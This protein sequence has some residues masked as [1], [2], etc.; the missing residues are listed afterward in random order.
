MTETIT[1]TLTNDNDEYRFLSNPQSIFALD[2]DDVLVASGRTPFEDILIDGGDGTDALTHQGRLKLG[3]GVTFND[4]EVLAADTVKVTDGATVDLSDFERN[5]SWAIYGSA[6]DETI[7]GTQDA[8]FIRAGAGNDTVFANAGDIVHMG[9]GDDTLQFVQDGTAVVDVNDK[10]NGTIRYANGDVIK[11]R[12]VENFEEIAPPV[13]TAEYVLDFNDGAAIS[14]GDTILQDQFVV[15][16]ST[17]LSNREGEI[18]PIDYDRGEVDS[19]QE[20]FNAFLPKTMG[21]ERTDGSDFDFKSVS[22]GKGLRDG[23]NPDASNLAQ[24]VEIIGYRDGEVAFSQT[25]TLEFGQTVTELNFT[26][27]D[28]L[29]FV[30]SGG[31]E[32]GTGVYSFDDLVFV[33]D[34]LPPVDTPDGP[35]EQVVDFD[36]DVTLV[37][38]TEVLDGQFIAEVSR[39]ESNIAGS[40]RSLDY[41]AG[42]VDDDLEAFNSWG[43]TVG[44][45]SA[46]GDTFDF[47]SVS[48][49][50]GS[51]ADKTN[52]NPDGL[53]NTVE[54]TGFDDGVALFTQTVDLTD[55]H[56]VQELNWTGIDQIEFR[57]TGGG[58]DGA[59]I[60]NGGVFSMDDLVFIA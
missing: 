37:T 25:V 29:E 18:R 47:K 49:A 41:D 4:M 21:F 34:A 45:R 30:A 35:T 19:D 14:N 27:I 10:G 36:N 57:A 15:D 51:R 39:G 46:D 22:L 20:A 32:G 38:G 42:D 28:R 60:T 53:A 31:S 50:N 55:T 3:D 43:A 54:I 59:D 12:G 16:L 44:F 23:G 24:T 1:T 33:A 26:A 58:Y 11:F 7:I 17:G 48:L 2:G 52:A 9:K 40:L 6:G 13:E 5:D 8:D 56:T